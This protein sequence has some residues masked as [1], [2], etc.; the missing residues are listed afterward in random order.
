MSLSSN[1]KR[2][3]KEY[4]M[5]Q[6]EFAAK[7]NISRQAV[8]KWETD[9]A[10][11]DL[12]NLKTI[13]KLF[14]VSLDAL[15]FDSDARIIDELKYDK[16]IQ[17]EYDGMHEWEQYS[18]Q[19]SVEFRQTLEEGIDIDGY[20]SLFHAA[21]QMPG[22]KYKADIADVLF[23]LI[24]NTP[25]K[26]NYGYY[27]PSELN[28][29]QQER[30]AYIFQRK[31]P[32]AKELKNKIY[33]AWIGRICGCLLGKP[34][35]GMKA[36]ELTPFLK[37]NG[38]F[39]MRRYILSG[40][41]TKEICEKY[42]YRLSGKCYP[43]TLKQCAP[44]D[45][46]TNYTVLA[47][48]IIDKYGRDFTPYDVSRAWL[49]YQPKSAYCTAERVAFRNF[50]AGYK[51]PESAMYK[52]PYRE[53]IGAQ[54]R[55][56][57]FGYINPGNPELAAEMAWRDASI[58]HVKNGIYGEMFVAAMIACAAVT[59]NMIDIICGGLAQIPEHSR[60][61]EAV[62]NI[63]IDY[64]KGITQAE[65]FENIHKLYND[66]DIHDWCHTISNA[67]IVVAALL[68][69][70]GDYGKS[71]CMAVET[72]FDTDCNGAT[73]GSVLGMRNGIGKIPDEWKNPI[74]NTLD[75]SIFGIGKVNVL[76]CVDMTLKHIVLGG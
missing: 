8:Q 66:H 58:S 46:D 57:Y 37:E 20:E 17:P 10:Q 73:V 25:L 35:E 64:D 24:L 38:N 28:G 14:G 74:H 1:I 41:V 23:H 15:V 75:T 50:V 60:L 2:I 62:T 44:V 54:I 31:M 51:P 67:M 65:C 59:D 76:D 16:T 70:G 19:L 52:N 63:L 27:E 5:S 49:D 53:W 12:Y 4:N 42:T 72:G 39:P 7:L 6:E 32:D 3:R 55:G 13:A 48:L 9:S 21:S 43:D 33:G 40:D 26:K 34:V 68:Y 47:Q 30:K 29:I 71:I 69:G 18:K 45:D 36:D 11:P 22:S 56:D 61:Y